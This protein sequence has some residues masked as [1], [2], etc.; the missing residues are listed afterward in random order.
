MV[1]IIFIFITPSGIVQ[2]MS[3]GLTSTPFIVRQFL[4]SYAE[5]P[6]ET[7]MLDWLGGE[8]SKSLSEK[9]PE[10]LLEEADIHAF[11]VEDMLEEIENQQN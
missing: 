5:K 8:L 11:E 4:S 9:S 7:S 1:E 3:L 2:F 10:E 6:K